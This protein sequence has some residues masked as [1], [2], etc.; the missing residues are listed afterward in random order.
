MPNMIFPRKDGRGS[1]IR[2]SPSPIGEIW[3]S[4]MNRCTKPNHPKW[5]DYGGRGIRVCRRWFVFTKFVAD[6]GTRPVEMTL[7]RRN[8]NGNYTPKNC[9]WATRKTQANNRR[10]CCVLGFAGKRMNV[11]QWAEHLGVARGQIYDRIRRGWPIADVLT[12]PRRPYEYRP[13]A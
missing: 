12:R 7:E 11:T 2:N 10:S 13:A 6:M 9:Y 5:P 8:N 3:C 4:M 1:R